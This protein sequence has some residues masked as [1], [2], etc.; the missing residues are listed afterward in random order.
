MVP[1]AISSL[2]QLSS[3]FQKDEPRTGYSFVWPIA[4]RLQVQYLNP[5][6][7]VDDDE[8][9]LLRAGECKSARNRSLLGFLHILRSLIQEPGIRLQTRLTENP[10]SCLTSIRIDDWREAFYTERQ[11]MSY[12]R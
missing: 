3:I 7:I 10:R 9:G 1:H 4:R 12:E 6:R 11:N 5:V 8:Q 2:A